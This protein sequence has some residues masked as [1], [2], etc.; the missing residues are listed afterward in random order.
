[1]IIKIDKIDIK[2]NVVS[3]TIDTVQYQYNNKTDMFYKK[4]GTKFVYS[5]PLNTTVKKIISDR[6]KSFKEYNNKIED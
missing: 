6:L 5:K 3:F 2:T 4:V 1:M